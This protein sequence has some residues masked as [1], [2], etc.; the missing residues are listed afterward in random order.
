MADL[1]FLNPFFKK[2]FKFFLK[3]TN[4]K[5]ITGCIVYVDSEQEA[6]I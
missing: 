5:G 1:S 4:G 6:G 2:K 3:R